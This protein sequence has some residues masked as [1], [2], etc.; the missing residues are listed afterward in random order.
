MCINAMQSLKFFD[1]KADSK[2]QVQ[3]RKV[4]I[5]NVFM[6]I[7][8]PVKSLKLRKCTGRKIAIAIR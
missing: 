2:I 4:K 5:I 3:N 8:R 1:L 7:C 6:K